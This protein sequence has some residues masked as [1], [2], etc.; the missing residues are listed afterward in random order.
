MAPSS[1]AD[2]VTLRD[3]AANIVN[4]ATRRDP[5]KLTIKVKIGNLGN[6]MLKVA[7]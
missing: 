2:A 1:A 4:P 6:F 3:L 7:K 5:T